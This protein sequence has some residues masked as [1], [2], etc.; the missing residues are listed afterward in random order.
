[1]G[2][3]ST[4]AR[5]ALPR[6]VSLTYTY[7]N[8]PRFSED[9]AGSSNLFVHRFDSHSLVSRIGLTFSYEFDLDNVTIV[10]EASAEWAH[11][12]LDVDRTIVSRLVAVGHTT[13]AVDGV[14]PDRD[15]AL[16][17]LGVT[18]YFGKGFSV[19]GDYNAELRRNYDSHGFT[20]GIRYEF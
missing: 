6:I 1:M 5:R 10:P 7:Y 2:T 18:A 15:G 17:G 16:L 4:S 3:T 12:Y 20:V 11:E 19:Y 8:Q 9:G 13:F 14:T